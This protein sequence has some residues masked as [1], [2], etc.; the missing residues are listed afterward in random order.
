MEF[1]R[2]I[3]SHSEQRQLAQTLSDYLDLGDLGEF[4]SLN[5]WQAAEEDSRRNAQQAG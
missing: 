5:V 1:R 3:E 4:G 2:A